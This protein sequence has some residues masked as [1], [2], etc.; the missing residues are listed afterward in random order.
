MSRLRSIATRSEVISRCPT[1][2]ATVS[3]S[4]I[5]RSSP[6]IVIFMKLKPSL[7]RGFLL[8]RPTR[9]ISCARPHRKP[10]LIISTGRR[11]TNHERQVALPQRRQRK[12]QTC[13]PLAIRHFRVAPI[14]D[15]SINKRLHRNS[16]LWPPVRPPHK[17]N[18][19]KYMPTGKPRRRVHKLHLNAAGTTIRARSRC[20]LRLENSRP[21]VF[22]HRTMLFLHPIPQPLVIK[23]VGFNKM[24]IV[25]R[26]PVQH[27]SILVHHS[28]N[29]RVSG[30]A[31]L[32]LN[33]KHLGAN[34][35]VGVEP[36]TH[37]GMDA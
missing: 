21:Q 15:R 13:S 20:N 32:G 23:F 1:S 6:L 9:R 28:I 4:G 31:I 3:P 10:Q 35:N 7:I 29:Y 22:N 34:L 24:P 19:Q 27:A 5:S 16:R 26:T 36:G 12:P 25:R 18:V 8:R 2:P 11:R 30:T 17:L 37:A 33:V 14:L